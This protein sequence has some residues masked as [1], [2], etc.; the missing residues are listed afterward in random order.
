[1]IPVSLN[2]RFRNRPVTGVER[3]AGEVASH[4]AKHDEVKMDEVSPRNPLSGLR[5]HGWEQWI[6]PR[7]CRRD[8]I[9][10]SPCNTGPVSVKRQLVVI[11]DAAVWDCPDAF[12]SKFRRL[13]QNLLPA[14]AK[15][16]AAVGT[17]SEF[18][19]ERLAYQL[20]IPI[21]KI[22]VLGNAASG[23]FAP[24]QGVK[25]QTPNLLCVGSLDPRKNFGRLVEAW[26]KLTKE[27]RLPEKARLQIVGSA[28]PSNFSHFEVENAP[29]IDWLG[30]LSDEEL[31]RR[32][33]NASAFV[34][35]SLY[36]GFGL[37]PLEAMACGC[38]V[39]LSNEASLPEV[40]G[41]AFDAG[42]AS[43]AAVYFDPRSVS[44][45]ADAIE[46]M[47]SLDEETRARLTGNAIRHAKQFSWDAVA[48]RTFD[49]LSG[50]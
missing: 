32:Y 36:E 17:V 43:G 18:S 34:F 13:Y 41:P 5:G 7:R 44:E 21:E 12:S 29:G 46:N 27:E 30:R 20:N 22:H 14:L 31:I 19:K 33:Q 39:L 45:M 48:Q 26:M 24:C 25:E 37:P 10:F 2:A 35:P 11:H 3:F 4:L 15:R 47:L 40:G 9:L 49:I 28:K 6:L 50:L 38:P 23:D 16:A 1:M 42:S 8:S